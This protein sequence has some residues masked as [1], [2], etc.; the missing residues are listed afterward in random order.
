MRLLYTTVGLSRELRNN[1]FLF[2]S[3]VSS[4]SFSIK[5]VSW[6]S[7][8]LVEKCLSGDSWDRECTTESACVIESHVEIALM[9]AF[10][11]PLPPP[12]PAQRAST[13]AFFQLYQVCIPSSDMR[14]QLWQF[15]IYHLT[16]ICSRI[17]TLIYLFYKYLMSTHCVLGNV[18]CIE[19]TTEQKK[20]S[21]TVPTFMELVVW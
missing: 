7:L 4:H 10:P 11:F 9:F 19:D 6:Q 2:W 3:I 20:N 17:Y 1:S 8:Q 18:L 12:Q 15:L 16:F 13:G 14:G 21:D 5:L